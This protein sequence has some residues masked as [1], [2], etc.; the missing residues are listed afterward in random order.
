MAYLNSSKQ[1]EE[2]LR[3]IG[4]QIDKNVDLIVDKNEQP[5]NFKSVGENDVYTI[6]WQ[7]SPY[8]LQKRH[9]YYGQVNFRK[10][11]CNGKENL[12]MALEILDGSMPESLF[13]F[14]CKGSCDHTQ[15]ISDGIIGPQ[16][17]PDP[18]SEIDYTD[19]Y[20]Q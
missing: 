10:Y 15:Y 2:H 13:L 14:D 20:L 16:V 8:L 19:G 3:Q 11:I 17:I 18:N 12:R 9:K 7:E 1:F 5:I 6:Y 4:Y